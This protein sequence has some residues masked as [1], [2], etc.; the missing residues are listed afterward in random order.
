MADNTGDGLNN[1]ILP[2][3]DYLDIP[4][5]H[6]SVTFIPS[7]VRTRNLDSS[8]ESHCRRT[9]DRLLFYNRKGDEL[10]GNTDLIRLQDQLPS[11]TDLSSSKEPPPNRFKFAPAIPQSPPSHP[12]L[13]TLDSNT[14][15]SLSLDKSALEMEINFQDLSEH[16]VST[17]DTPSSGNSN[18]V[19]AVPIT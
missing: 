16:P 6:R 11:L 3:V 14:I 9:K 1:K 13:F 8:L 7:V 19:D 12:L 18:C 15:P 5:R 4:L 2:A 17:A 10:I